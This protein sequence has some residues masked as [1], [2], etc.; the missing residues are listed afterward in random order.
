MGNFFNTREGQRRCLHCLQWQ[1]ED[2]FTSPGKRAKC[3]DCKKQT[4][5]LRKLWKEYIQNRAKKEN[6]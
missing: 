6:Q 3:A 2:N 1:F 4:K 5:L